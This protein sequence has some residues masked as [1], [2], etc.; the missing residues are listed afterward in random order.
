MNGHITIDINECDGKQQILV[1]GTL[2]NTSELDKIQILESMIKSFK[3]TMVDAVSG[4]LANSIVN[5][6]LPGTIPTRFDFSEL[7]KY[8]EKEDKK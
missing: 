4:L 1:E 3:L 2:N 6:F 5:D 8:I 7:L